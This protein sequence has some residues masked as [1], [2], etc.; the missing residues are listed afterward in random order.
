MAPVLPSR[1]RARY[2]IFSAYGLAMSETSRIRR[3]RA[4]TL[5]LPS[6]STAQAHVV[7]ERRPSQVARQPGLG[8]GQRDRLLERP[9]RSRSAARS[10][11]PR[12]HTAPRRRSGA[13][14]GTILPK[15]SPKNARDGRASWPRSALSYTSRASAG[16]GW[17]HWVWQPPIL[18]A[19]GL[20]SSPQ[21]LPKTG[22]FTSPSRFPQQ[23]QCPALSRARF[24]WGTS[25][26][27]HLKTAPHCSPSR[28]PADGS[29]A[30]SLMSSQPRKKGWLP[31]FSKE[32]GSAD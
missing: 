2:S 1:T 17:F 20:T 19:D 14:A 9:G 3:V 16:W 24:F 30:A 13:P 23:P 6:R 15:V 21:G 8:L 11:V 31:T 29:Q 12:S 32:A 5:R 26:F 28:A 10:G 18:S 7:A 25:C 27:A 4:P 22:R